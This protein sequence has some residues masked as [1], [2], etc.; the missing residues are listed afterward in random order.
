MNYI[1]PHIHMFSRT[2]NDYE[3]MKQAG[4]VAVIEPS[5]WLGQPRTTVG[6]FKDYFSSIVEWEPFRAS[7]FEIKHYCAIGLNPKE[8]NNKDLSIEVMKLLPDFAKRDTVVAIG[9]IGYDDQTPTEDRF[10]REQIELAK[11]LNLPI[12]VHTPHRDKL[13]GTIRSMDVLE[14]HNVDPTKVVIDHNT[15]I[16]VKTVLDR[17]YWAGFT[18]YPDTKMDSQRMAAV[19]EEYGPE[20]I[21]INSSADWGVSDPLSVPKTA[22]LMA[23]RGIS[24]STI[25]DTCYQNALRVYSQNTPMTESDWQ[26]G[27]TFDQSTLYEGNSVLRGQH[28]KKSSPSATIC[29]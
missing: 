29:S 19:V 12:M 7:Q 26:T 28:P 9:E 11:Q 20:R 2:T 23:E 8:A 24:S 16:T 18:I 22:Q 6:T 14:E 17:G 4:I 21:I 10:F 5:F 3:A 13:N 25:H 27:I 15:E 1:D